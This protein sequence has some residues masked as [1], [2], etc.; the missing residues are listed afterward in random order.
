MA[1]G[2]L[3]THAP[4]GSAS[5]AGLELDLTGA[6]TL[7]P[8][9]NLDVSGAGLP[10]NVA[11]PGDALPSG[12]F[13]GG[14][15]IGRGGTAASLAA[16]GATF[17]SVERPREFGA[18]SGSSTGAS[19]RGGGRVHVKA[20]SVVLGGA[21]R[22]NGAPA[23]SSP[24]AGGGA[25][26]SVFI[27]A[28]NIAG[29]APIEAKGGPAV[30]L[31]GGGG[32]GAVT[33]RFTGTS[34][35]TWR[36]LSSARGGQL[37]S[38]A[39][40]ENAGAGSLLVVGPATPLGELR[41]DNSGTLPGQATE[42]P[43][44]GNGTAQAGSSGALLKTGRATPVPQFFAGHFVEVSTGAM[45]KG[46]YRIAAVSGGDLTLESAS[47]P[48]PA[49]QPGDTFQGVYR[50]DAFALAGSE[51]F[52]SPDPIRGAFYLTNATLA[53]PISAGLTANGTVELSSPASAG[54]FP[55]TFTSSS[56]V[57][58][59]A[60][61]MVT[62]PAG[63]TSAPF[64]VATTATGVT[65]NAVITAQAGG[66]SRNLPL[67]VVREILSDLSFTTTPTV[68]GGSN[69]VL[70]A[71]LSL[72]AGPGGAF[73]PVTSSSPAA[74]L[75]PGA[76]ISIAQG[77][78]QGT[79]SIPTIP[80][81]AVTVAD[82]TGTYAGTTIQKP[83]TINPPLVNNL[84]L[85]PQR[86]SGN[87][88]VTLAAFLNAAAGPAGAD[89]VLTAANPA[90]VPLPATIRI[91]PGATTA[92]LTF[93]TGSVSSYTVV[94]I[95]GTFNGTA[96]RDLNVT[97]EVLID[98]TVSASP[99]VGGN[100]VTGNVVLSQ[101]ASTGGTGVRVELLDAVGTVLRST[102]VTVPA[103]STS[104]P[105]SLLA[106]AVAAPMSA[107]VKASYSGIEKSAAVT[108]NPASLLSLTTPATIGGGQTV[109]GTINLDGLPSA[110]IQVTLESSNP[111]V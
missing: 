33:V 10:W 9:G 8:G 43:A 74:P 86:V 71:T 21:I 13:I 52:T 101:A 102:T 88:S 108:L 76:G 106:P 110:P 2:G 80:V 63:A 29:D 40:L 77:A 72:A 36:S 59:P 73:I 103:G 24:R 1:V 17:G 19:V 68:T 91:N 53:S 93:T 12:A 56:P 65:V 79:L 32:G 61:A 38:A 95:T 66:S 6:L 99:I 69:R 50:V 25:G 15:H 7:Q 49:V 81:D 41:I 55:V 27:E 111:A 57:A 64:S 87:T 51:S 47:G 37:S 70:R 107:S 85:T 11:P 75:S 44:L 3:L 105:Y 48:A 26:G 58:A 100:P 28:G 96:S 98:V 39:A 60:P 46:T 89:V 23:Q 5:S 20:G 30:T 14:S 22:A 42:L 67:A 78:T 104:T 94:P 34:S 16:S 92:S 4:A 31:S 18:G 45:L 35:G 83:L 109:T 97:P 54:G 82:L 90:V 62:I 84:T